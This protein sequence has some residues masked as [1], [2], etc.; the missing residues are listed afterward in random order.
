[1]IN[2]YVIF[3]D[4]ASDIPE[5][6]ID[7]HNIS[8]IPMHFEI[9][10]KNYK[11]YPDGRE[12]DYFKFYE[13]LRAGDT[14]KTSQINSA[15][16]IDYFEPVLN[17]GLDILYIAFSSGLSGTYQSS[18]IAAEELMKR[19]PAQKIYC[20][21]SRCASTGQGMLV[22]YAAMKKDEGLDIDEL[23]NWV[24]Q[25]RD[26]LCH[27]FT[28]NDLNYLKRGGRLSASAAIVGTMRSFS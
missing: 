4:A 14:A 8:V 15:E 21:D 5:T 16:F 28:V 11:H 25:N 20:V 3:T 18:V 26:Y 23:K 2:G 10:G 1:M 19:Y 12:L 24:I 7:D 27:W 9:R 6:I 17:R 13:M 22:Y